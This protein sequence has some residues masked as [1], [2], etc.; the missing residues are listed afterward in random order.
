MPTKILLKTPFP[1]IFIPMKQLLI[2]SLF[3]LF[4]L[5][6]QSY[7]WD[8]NSPD[9][10]QTP[11]FIFY[12][13]DE[14]QCRIEAPDNWIFDIKNARLDNYSA[15]M[16]PDTSQYYNSKIII[17][18]WIFGTNEYSYET[19]ITADSLA[20][21]KEN[22]K[23]LFKK[24]DSILTETNQSVLYYETTDPGGEYDLAFVGY[25]PVDDEIIIYEMNIADRL[26]YPDA[27]HKF[28]K[29]LSRFELVEKE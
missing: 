1:Y 16:F 2:K 5:P 15:A 23:I 22:P 20:Y 6:C 28:R 27:D 12:E 19:F 11:D 3:L 17:Y 13:T 24:T 7:A 4:L 9:K 26:Y 25:I 29:A 14:Y 21:L 18:I 10:I 8:E